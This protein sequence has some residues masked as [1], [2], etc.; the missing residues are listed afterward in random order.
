MAKTSLDKSKIKI[1]LLEGIHQS[2]VDN[3]LNAGYTNIETLST[4]LSEDELVE[5]I[6]DV[7]FIGLRSR[8]QLT[9]RVFAAAEKLTAVGCFCIGT[10]QVDL[11][12]ALERGIPVFN[13]PYS[14][15]RSVAELVLAEAIML[16][17]GIPE[18]SARAHQGGW[19]KSA[20]NSHEARGKTLGI[21]G[22]GSIGAQLSVLAESLGFDVLYYD[23]ITK[24]AMGNARQV[25]SL[26]ELLARADVVSLHVP[27]VP[28]TRWMIGRDQLAL[29]K[30]NAIF[31]NASRGTVV[32]IEA[33]AEVL[34]SG[35]LLGAAIDVFPVEP[36]GT[37]EEFV[38][39][40]RGKE[41]VIL[42]PH[43]G[44]STLEAQENIGIEVS[45]KLITYSDNGTT[46]T[47]VNFPEVALPA[48][49]D[50]H[51]L[52]HIHE[53]VPG[54]MSEINKVL[55]DEGINISAQYLQTN[56]GVGYVVIDVDK[57]YGPKA[58]EA[59]KRVNHTLRLRVLYSE[60]NFEA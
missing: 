43:I 23:V 48:H 58:L 10:N 3:L 50:K 55:S 26:E 27:D 5:K 38:S 1:L 45:E 32:D 34:E 40:L 29:M 4:S 31:I 21:I 60:S 15:T 56:S 19:L 11:N 39:P 57:A 33:L 18:K 37:N 16:L 2:A 17:R 53:N 8:T 49:P 20:K 7:H 6:R 59:L 22:Y 30:Q 14:N 12:A 52:L 46:I 36:K 54:V 42:T 51:R 44:G 25:G 35:K 28:S 13:A 47:S 24:L 41:N 9:E